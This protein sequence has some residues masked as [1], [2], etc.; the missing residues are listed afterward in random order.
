VIVR[1][2]SKTDVGRQRSINEDSCYVDPDGKLV[3]VLDGMGGHK[4]GEVASQIAME[5]ISRFYEDY[6]RNQ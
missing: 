4:A 2:W 5:T 6:S 1:T 3:L